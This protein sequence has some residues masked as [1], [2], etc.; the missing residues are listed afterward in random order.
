MTI[1]GTTKRPPS[2]RNLCQEGQTTVNGKRS[3]KGKIVFQELFNDLSTSKWKK[4]KKFAGDPDYEFVLYQDNATNVYVK[5]KILHIKP[6]LLEDAYGEGFATNSQGIDLGA[7]CTGVYGTDQCVL[8]P[9]AWLILPPVISAQIS[10][11]DYFSFKYGIVEISAKL[12]KGD[13]I[14]PGLRYSYTPIG[15]FCCQ[16]KVNGDRSLSSRTVGKRFNIGSIRS[17]GRKDLEIF[18][19]LYYR[20]QMFL[21]L[22]VGVGGQVYPDIPEVHKPWVSGE[23]KAQ[24]NFYRNKDKWYNTWNDDSELLVDYIKVWAI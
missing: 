8:K 15:R 16:P 14:Y 21:S 3:C 17:R 20:L 19:V 11:M 1:N 4:E 13:W 18:D 6:T 10:T 22:G 2:N 7:T 23:P 5:D 12:P 9:R 24:L